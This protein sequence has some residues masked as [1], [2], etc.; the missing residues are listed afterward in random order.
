MSVTGPGPIQ[1]GLP[2]RLNPPATPPA[3]TNA[4]PPITPTD[5]VEI[6]SA[7]R[8]LDQLQQSGL[9]RA[10]RLA[11]IKAA[12]EAGEYETPQKLDAAL[13]RMLTAV[14]AELDAGNGEG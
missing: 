8:L 1:G 6:S 5:E 3:K 14:Q 10:E 13:Q 7:G 9:V 12:I 2:V 4:A 11:R